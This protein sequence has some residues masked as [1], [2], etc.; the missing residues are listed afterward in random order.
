MGK[1]G[2]CRSCSARWVAS[3]ALAI[4]ERFEIALLHGCRSGRRPPSPNRFRKPFFDCGRSSAV[5]RAP[6]D[7]SIATPTVASTRWH[8]RLRA[9]RPGPMTH[10]RNRCHRHYPATQRA[11][12]GC[13]K[14]HAHQ[15]ESRGHQF[16]NLAQRQVKYQAQHQPHLD[17]QIR[18]AG[19]AISSDSRYR[20][21]AGDCF[22][23]H[24]S[25]CLGTGTRYRT[26]PSSAP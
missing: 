18:I 1:L 2:G 14:R 23:R 10:F 3:P 19:L 9:R 25:D 17:H 22:I 26:P 11:M 12:V 15:L 24:Q 4:S 5:W 7:L 21:P 13:G 6:C 20:L 8:G 16:L